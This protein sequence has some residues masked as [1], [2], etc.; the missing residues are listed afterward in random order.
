MAKNRP[1]TVRLEP[2]LEARITRIA[3]LAKRS[4]GAV[5]E[6][7]ADEAERMRRYP[8]LRFRGPES[9]RRVWIVGTALDV[10]QVIEAFSDFGRDVERMVAET[11]LTRRQLDIALAYHREFRSEIDQ[12]IA[13]NRPTAQQ[14]DADYPFILTG[15]GHQ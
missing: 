15:T 10:W 3:K 11:D 14:V 8:G 6:E 9:A 4:K 7:L 1:F 2:G 5:L 13:A 12:A